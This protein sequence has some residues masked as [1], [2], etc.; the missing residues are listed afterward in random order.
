VFF[1][2]SLRS[3]A[4]LR[5]LAGYSR[6]CSAGTSGERRCA[7]AAW[8]CKLGASWI[9][10]ARS[11]SNAQQLLLFVLR[12]KYLKW[13]RR[14]SAPLRSAVQV[15]RQALACRSGT[16]KRFFNTVDARYYAFTMNLMDGW[17]VAQERI[18]CI[19]KHLIKTRHKHP[20]ESTN[21]RCVWPPHVRLSAHRAIK[22]QTFPS[23]V[24]SRQK[25]LRAKVNSWHGQTQQTNKAD[26]SGCHLRSSNQT[27]LTNQLSSSLFSS[28]KAEQHN[29]LR[30][31][32]NMHVECI[33]DNSHK[34][35]FCYDLNFSPIDIVHYLQNSI[36]INWNFFTKWQLYIYYYQNKNTN[37]DAH[38]KIILIY[39]SNQYL[40]IMI[41]IWW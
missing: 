20:C 34:L 40:I 24:A 27:M 39:F 7:P 22:S 10:D 26:K 38:R 12:D 32:R 36:I 14:A 5:S 2:C 33:A 6:R 23:V 11:R 4:A 37:D 3:C 17:L 31:S 41:K 25:R 13:P 1:I 8:L 21:P 9:I 19:Q 18:V 28:D 30:L 15:R 29:P 16:W 35:T